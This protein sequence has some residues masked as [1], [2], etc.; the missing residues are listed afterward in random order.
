MRSPIYLLASTFERPSNDLRTTFERPSLIFKLSL[1]LCHM[2]EEI[3]NSH[4]IAI[5]LGCLCSFSYL[6]TKSQYNGILTH[7]IIWMLHY[8]R[9]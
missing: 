1:L 2:V 3:V 6:C 4:F 5:L 8:G 7:S 9:V